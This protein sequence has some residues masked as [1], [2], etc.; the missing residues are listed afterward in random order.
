MNRGVRNDVLESLKLADD[1]SAVC[2]A[3]VS[4]NI[5]LCILKRNL[6]NP[7]DKHMRHRDDICPFPEET[8]HL[9]SW[10]YDYEIVIVHV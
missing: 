6:A 3:E 5:S 1:E 2:L 8:L 7:M 4:V 9:A 10:K